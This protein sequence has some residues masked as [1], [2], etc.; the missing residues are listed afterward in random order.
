MPASQNA[1]LTNDEGRTQ[2]PALVFPGVMAIEATVQAARAC[3]GIN[4]LPVLRN[5]IFHRP[6]II[7][8]GARVLI[9]TASGKEIILAET[10]AGQYFGELAGIDGAKRT[11]NVTALTRAELCIVPSTVFREILFTSRTC[12]DKILRLLTTRVRELDA[13]LAEHSIFDLKH[14]LYSELLRLSAEA[15]ESLQPVRMTH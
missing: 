4:E 14:R 7:P 15:D 10:K 11:A 3:A 9:R 2:H 1:G 6:L 5:L 12:C 8:E 13:R